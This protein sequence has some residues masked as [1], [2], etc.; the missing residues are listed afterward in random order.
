MLSAQALAAAGRLAFCGQDGLLG[1]VFHCVVAVV[2]VALVEAR[3]T[4]LVAD[5]IVLLA[6]VLSA[7]AG[8]TDVVHFLLV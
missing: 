2:A 4:G 5:A 6:I 7:I 1:H 8:L 3:Q